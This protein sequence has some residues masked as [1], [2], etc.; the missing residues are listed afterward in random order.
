MAIRSFANVGTADIAAGRQTKASRRILPVHLHGIA[1][2]KLVLLDAAVTLNDLAAWPSLQLE[3][4]KGDRKGQY[5]I[6]IN[7]QYRICFAWQAPDVF[8]VEIV[9][10]H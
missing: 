4:L 10:Y 7:G 6:R 5:S 1:L 9:D 8:E 2:E 3:K